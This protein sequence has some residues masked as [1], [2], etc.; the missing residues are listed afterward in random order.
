MGGKITISRLPEAVNIILIESTEEG[1]TIITDTAKSMGQ[2]FTPPDLAAEILDHAG[3]TVDHLIAH[4]EAWDV[5]EPSFGQGVFLVEIITRMATAGA[6]LGMTGEELARAVE[7]NLFGVEADA[8]LFSAGRSAAREVFS[9]ITGGAVT[10][11][12][13][14]LFCGDALDHPEDRTYS[15]IVGNPPYVRVHHMDADTRAKVKALTPGGGMG[16][17][18]AAFFLKF[19]PLTSRRLTFITPSS[20]I[21]NSS[22]AGLRARLLDGRHIEQVIDHGSEQK[23]DDAATYTAITTLVPGGREDFTYISS[24]REITV[25]YQDDRPADHP[26]VPRAEDAG[27]TPLSE[28]A[29]VQNGLATLADRVFIRPAADWAADGVETDLLRPAVKAGRPGGPERL[30]L[31]PYDLDGDR[32]VGLTEDEVRA[33]PSTWAYLE[34]HRERL[35]SRSVDRSAS[36]FHFG[37]SQALG[38]IGV[39]K[40]ALSV[41]VSPEAS[42]VSWRRVPAGTAVYSGLVITEIPGGP[43]LDEIGRI[44]DGE[45]FYDHCRREGKP[46]SGDWVTISSPVTRRFPA[47]F[48][49]VTGGSDPGDLV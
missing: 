40:I 8:A 1:A 41:S 16:E 12:L 15:H 2:V 30:I 45:A 19:L 48:S 36:W 14:G 20:W 4:P 7:G 31:T 28:L 49:E 27:T 23:F 33:Y 44:L 18:Y 5:L 24:G 29:R 46:I 11:S 32:P 35:S 47:A 17:L 39:E 13:P 38:T 9:E 34:G 10:V 37:R 6:H 26:L 25:T 21:R 3:Y 43:G 42:R 22:Q